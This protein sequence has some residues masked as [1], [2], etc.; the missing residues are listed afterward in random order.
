MLAFLPVRYNSINQTTVLTPMAFFKPVYDR[1]DS[2]CGSWR[3]S[4]FPACL[5]QVL[6]TFHARALWRELVQ[7]NTVAA[8]KNHIATCNREGEILFNVS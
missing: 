8:L 1:T 2:A 5:R 6:R 7:D 3:P 4:P